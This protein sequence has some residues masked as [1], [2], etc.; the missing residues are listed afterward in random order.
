MRSAILRTQ[1]TSNRVFLR[2]RPVGP[3]CLLKKLESTTKSKIPLRLTSRQRLTRSNDGP[4]QL[5][6]TDGRIS[7]ATYI[8]I[9]LA[10]KYRCCGCHIA[11]Y[12]SIPSMGYRRVIPVPCWT[13]D[14]KE[15]SLSRFEDD[16]QYTSAGALKPSYPTA[17]IFTRRF[18]QKGQQRANNCSWKQECQGAASGLHVDPKGKEL[19]GCTT[20]TVDGLTGDGPPRQGSWDGRSPFALGPFAIAVVRC[21][22]SM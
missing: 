4:R 10:R 21:K 1:K 7:V 13:T 6:T 2:T 5:V 16:D 9:A 14:W 11:A 18:Q 3:I 19:T 20:H 8:C 17:K 22:A 12:P 15:C